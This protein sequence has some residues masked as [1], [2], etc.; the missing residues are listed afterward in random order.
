MFYRSSILK[1]IAIINR[2]FPVHN[3]IPKQGFYRSLRVLSSPDGQYSAAHTTKQSSY[4][5]S[6]HEKTA[7]LFSNSHQ[8]VSSVQGTFLK[9]L[10]QMSK[11]TRVL[12]IGTFTGYSALCMAEGL[13]GRGSEAKVVTLEK[14]IEHFKVAKENIESS[15]LGHLIE[16]KLGDAIDT[17][18]NLDNAVQYDL[19]F[20]DADKGNYIN[21]YNTVLERNLL[22]DDG[23]IVA[24]NVLFRGLVSQVAKTKETKDLSQISSTVKHLHS[25]NEYIANDRRTIQVLLPCFDGITLIRKNF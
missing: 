16:L 14:N 20:I 1:R 7:S 22:S 15:G 9:F 19:I 23:I 18:L 3:S 12:E 10:V 6:I 21:Y 13:K 17:L 11:A 25:F 24:D 8:M 5:E 4:L 2:F